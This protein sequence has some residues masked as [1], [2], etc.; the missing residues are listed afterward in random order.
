MLAHA[1]GEVEGLEGDVLEKLGEVKRQG[2]LLSLLSAQRD[3]KS[4]DL[5][6][7]EK[8]EKE[9][10]QHVKMKEL[11]ILDLTK[12][13]NEISNRLKE[14]SAL[15]EVVKN[16]RN[17]YVN[18]I[19][20]ST[21]G[22]SEMR[23]KIRILLSEVE[24]LGNESTAKDTALA[25]EKNAHQH[26]QVQRDALRQDMN[27]LLSEYR[28]KQSVVEQQIQEIDK[29]NVVINT[30]EKEML[31]LKSRY[32][33]AVE[34]RN[35]TGVQLIDRND[36]LCVLYERSN[37]QQQ[38]LK[39]GELQLLKKTEELRLLRLQTEE[40]KRQYAAARK[41]LPEI[42]SNK[43]K[44]ED[45]EVQLVEFRRKTDE[46]SNLLED[47]NNAERWRP[48]EGEDPTFEQL[49]GKI[50]TLE[51]R[52]NL[53]R[54]QLLEKELVL[55]E[56]SALT[57]KLRGQAVSR[58]DSA[59]EFVDQLND[60]QTKIRETT[61]KMLASVSELSM[62]QVCVFTS[63]SVF[64]DES[65][66]HTSNNLQ[67]IILAYFPHLFFSTA[68]LLL[69]CSSGYCITATAREGGPRE[70]TGSSQLARWPWGGAHRRCRQGL[71]PHR[72]EP[73]APRRGSPSARRK[74]GADADCRHYQDL[75]RAAALRLHSRRHRYSQAI[76]PS[77]AIQT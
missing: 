73:R 74:N 59:K 54:E 25:K 2:Q 19:Q 77:C 49:S 23:E 15:Y 3:I 46:C 47:P 29:L 42:E 7:V 8:K 11:I 4:R 70:H 53:K 66:C 35:V 30:M 13:C 5:S 65:T 40:L 51:D 20:S 57:N 67:I 21:Q 17:K 56:V 16:E 76:W 75:R 45:L 9:A 38:A 33:K 12:R 34:E 39:A 68:G 64:N 61:K 43:V 72:E 18:L 32:E 26:S 6:R 36:E 71:G 44:I 24:I 58:R 22:L 60:F 41:R 27:G 52:L 10:R 50:R 48:L 1:A 63:C 69:V 55:E 37:Q 14:F 28:A 62:Y 31:E